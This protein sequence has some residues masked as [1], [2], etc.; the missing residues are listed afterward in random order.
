MTTLYSAQVSLPR[1]FITVSPTGTSHLAG[2]PNA[3]ADFGPDSLKTGGGPTESMGI[4]EAIAASA[5]L[6]DGSGN[7][8]CVPVVLL[9]GVFTTKEAIHLAPLVPLL[10][11]RYYSHNEDSTGTTV[12]P[13]PGMGVFTDPCI[14]DSGAGGAPS[15]LR[16]SLAL[17]GVNFL[18]NGVSIDGLHLDNP[19]HATVQHCSFSGFKVG[20]TCEVYGAGAPST[21]MGEVQ[22]TDVVCIESSDTG[23]FINGSSG[24]GLNQG[25]KY[26]YLM[27]C[28][29]V[30]V[31]P[32]PPKYGF[33]FVD[34]SKVS[35]V[36]LWAFDFSTAGISVEAVNVTAPGEFVFVDCHS[37]SM[38]N[39]GIDFN[40]SGALS[41]SGPMIVVGGEASAAAGEKQFSNASTFSAGVSS[42]VYQLITNVANLNGP[43][44]PAFTQQNIPGSSGSW[45]GNAPSS[46]SMFP[47]S[48]VIYIT[49]GTSPSGTGASASVQ[50]LPYGA[51]AA[52]KI[53]VPPPNSPFDCTVILRPGDQIAI[54]WTGSGYSAPSW[55][56][57]PLS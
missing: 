44:G 37:D 17:V 50:V 39:S 11:F 24:S 40:Q 6:V 52:T 22:I 55:F 20:L 21:P 48:S 28:H 34:V 12:Q 3:G 2:V 35:G 33:R 51:S 36:N 45:L 15:T 18:A 31:N 16:P 30:S 57:V 38:G 32:T 26:F 8:A 27:N 5:A 23:F 19:D 1:S 54:F 47:F 42:S 49:G 4:N 10:S 7:P 46:G 29:A 43:G 14:I 13:D 25:G 53:R 56:W 9:G 41:T